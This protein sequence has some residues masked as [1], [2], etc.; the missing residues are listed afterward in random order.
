MN[1][2]INFKELPNGNLKI[3]L[4]KEG[5][6]ELKDLMGKKDYLGIWLDLIDVYQEN[7]SY[8]MVHPEKIAALT[9][10]PIIGLN[11]DYDD[12]GE[13]E[14]NPDLKIWW[15]PEYQAVSE[16]E[17]LLKHRSIVFTKAD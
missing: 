12:N 3:T 4:T 10:S 11:V 16:F 14:D 1:T 9:D 15:Y 13:I 17:Q 7:G 6:A 8:Q 5:R 2:Y